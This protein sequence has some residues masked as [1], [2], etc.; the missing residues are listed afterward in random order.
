[1]LSFCFLGAPPSIDSS[2]EHIYETIPEERDELEPI[3]CSPYYSHDAMVPTKPP[4]QPKHADGRLVEQWLRQ[5]HQNPSTRSGHK[6][7]RNATTKSISLPRSGGH[8]LPTQPTATISTL[9]PVGRTSSAEDPDNSS[10]AYQTGGSCNSANATPL[11]LELTANAHNH[12]HSSQ[13]T[14]VL[15]TPASSSATLLPSGRIPADPAPAA[16]SS[17]SRRR[18]SNTTNSRH[19]PLQ[20]QRTLLRTRQHHSVY[21]SY[22]PQQNLPQPYPYPTGTFH[23]QYHQQQHKQ[24]TGGST[25][26]YY[27]SSAA[28]PANPLSAD[29]MYTNMA[30][31][32]QTILLQQRLF[33]HAMIG[34]QPHDQ[35]PPHPPPPNAQPAKQ[36]T[37]PSL[38]QYQFVSGSQ[39]VRER[40]I[41]KVATV[42]I[43]RHAYIL[44]YTCRMIIM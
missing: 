8:V 26:A 21:P 10:S 32:Q 18:S 20:Q 15:N 19:Q 1:M 31:L 44:L 9:T 23:H 12:L 40:E 22:V 7:S 4:T 43:L 34:R 39:Q 6:S 37:A 38:S 33:R 11:T 29:T 17:S 14:L 13:S 30:N 27:Y 25:A 35:L 2:T 5:N 36:F 3:Y 41:F 16:I 28:D 24:V 42:T